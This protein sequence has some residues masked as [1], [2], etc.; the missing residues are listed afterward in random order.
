MSTEPRPVERMDRD[1]LAAE[2]RELRAHVEDLREFRAAHAKDMALVKQAIAAFYDDD[3]LGDDWAVEDLPA[4][5]DATRER[6]DD[7]LEEC[8]DRVAALGARDLDSTG[9]TGTDR[10][11]RIRRALVASAADHDAERGR[12]GMNYHEVRG[13]FAGDDEGISRSWANKLVDRAAEGH[14]AFSVRDTSGGPKQV[15]VDLAQV[16][17]TDPLRGEHDR[18]DRDA[19]R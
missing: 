3:A 15:R 2:V 19:P 9:S 10:V 16:D 17:R 4:A 13:L 11:T 1:D 5:G 6:I 14:P 7:R 8:D 12:A 18:E